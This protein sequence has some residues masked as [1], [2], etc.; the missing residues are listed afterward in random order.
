MS[1]VNLRI[2]FNLKKLSN[3]KKKR[4][5]ISLK[6]RKKKEREGDHINPSC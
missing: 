5:Y 6:E 2:Y 3:L 1:I 4:Y